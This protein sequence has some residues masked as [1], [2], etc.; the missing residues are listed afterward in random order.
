MRI[1]SPTSRGYY[2]IRYSLFDTVCAV[3]SPA[4][5]LW[6][7]DATFF[8]QEAVIYCLISLSFSLIAF[9]VFRV[10][11]GVSRYFSVGDAVDVVKAVVSAELTTGV[12]LFIFTRLDNIPR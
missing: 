2:R 11:E 8:S 12:I 10:H 5:A 9:S 3:G 1:R 4:L 6:A 7:R